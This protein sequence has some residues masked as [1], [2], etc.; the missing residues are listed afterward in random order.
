[1]PQ[2]RTGHSDCGAVQHPHWMFGNKLKAKGMHIFVGKYEL[3]LIFKTMSQI[4]QL[5]LGRFFVHCAFF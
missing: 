1:M 4:S 3:A 5:R 2:L